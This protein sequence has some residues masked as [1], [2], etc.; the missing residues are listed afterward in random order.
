MTRLGAAGLPGAPKRVIALHIDYGNRPES[1]AESAFVERWCAEEGVE[2]K[3]RAI[4]EIRRGITGRDEYEQ[5]SRKIRY[6]FY[7]SEIRA[8]GARAV[9][10]GHHR[11]DVQ[12]N[13]VTN[14]M[15][16]RFYSIVLLHPFDPF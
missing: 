7:R 3:V 15:R 5:L 6:D 14:V 4:E 10:V 9:F 13:I 8:A 16:V 12:E 11:G 2:F 1:K